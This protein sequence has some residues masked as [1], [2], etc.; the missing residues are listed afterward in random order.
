VMVR[1]DPT[2]AATE[3]EDNRSRVAALSLEAERLRAFADQR[4][5]DFSSVDRKYASLLADQTAIH[6]L[7]TEN[8]KREREVIQQQVNQKRSELVVLRSHK[9]S[10]REQIG[11][12]KELTE[13]RKNLMKSGHVSRVVY[14]RTKQELK[15]AQGEL[16]EV[17]GNI[18]KA[19]QAIAEAEGKLAEVESK[20]G[21]DA[22]TT[23]GR[24]T[25]ELERL[26]GTVGRLE[27]RVKRTEIRAPVKGIV[28]GLKVHT[29]G[30]VTPPGGTISE[31]VPL[32]EELVVEA[33][34]S[35]SDIGHIEIG[36]EAK[37]IVT[38]YDFARFGSVEGKVDNISATTFLQ[39]DGTLNY[40][41]TI[42]LERNFVGD[43]PGRYPILPGMITEVSIYTGE[44]TL[45]SYLLRPVYVAFD[46]GFGER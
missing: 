33:R 12:A 44:K 42:K 21:N 39:E 5:P 31:I 43:Q 17:Q 35:P 40:R 32:D 6:K 7:Q 28:K 8:R 11:I 37:V 16:R 2:D 25:A 20:R 29:I 34:V 45:L 30:G 14:L 19:N 22:A 18:A 26:R 24:V 4:E 46:R 41:A 36:Q 9:R 13:M 27:D 23:M 1:L 38:T 15:A 10:L 3:L